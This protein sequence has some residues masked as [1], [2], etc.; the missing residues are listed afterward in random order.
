MKPSIRLPVVFELNTL[1]VNCLKLSGIGST[2]EEAFQDILSNNPDFYSMLKDGSF[3]YIGDHLG[4]IVVKTDKLYDKLLE[5]EPLP[6]E[7]KKPKNKN[8]KDV[9]PE[10]VVKYGY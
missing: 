1:T 6:V 3:D 9:S 2:K 5:I 4:V 8:L 10:D 7:V